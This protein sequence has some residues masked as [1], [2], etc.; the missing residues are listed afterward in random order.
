MNLLDLALIFLRAGAASFGG[1]TAALGGLRHDLVD[2][3]PVMTARD[4]ENAYSL[5][6]ATPGPGILYLIPMGFYAAGAPGAVVALVAFL[7]PPLILQIVVASQWEAL[8]HSPWI[9]AIDRALVP[10]SIGLIAASFH[11]LGAP[12]LAE[13]AAIVALVVAMLVSLVFRPTPALV[14]IAGGILG[15]LGV[16]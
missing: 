8:S 16:I 6:Q 13:P 1:G 11:A 14:V 4:F 2:Q 5:G 3:H 7:T 12:L 10:I 9:R 15:L